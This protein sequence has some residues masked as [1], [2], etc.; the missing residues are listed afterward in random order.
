MEERVK[1][2]EET[3]VNVDGRRKTRTLDIKGGAS[4]CNGISLDPLLDEEQVPGKEMIPTLLAFPLPDWTLPPLFH[5]VS[6][7][8]MSH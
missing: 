3:L 4:D 7:H 6:L 8:P 2:K 5:T 1:F